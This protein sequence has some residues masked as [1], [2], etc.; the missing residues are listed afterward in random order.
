MRN[1]QG[2]SRFTEF[3]NMSALYD[4]RIEILSVAH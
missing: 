4:I 1:F 3:T 2:T